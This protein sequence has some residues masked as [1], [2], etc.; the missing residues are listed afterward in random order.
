MFHSPT[1]HIQNRASERRRGRRRDHHPPPRAES[2]SPSADDRRGP[3]GCESV[4]MLLCIANLAVATRDRGRI[5]EGVGRAA[6]RGASNI[7]APLHFAWR[8]ALAPSRRR[9]VAP[10]RVLAFRARDGEGG[11]RSVVCLGARRSTSSRRPASHAHTHGKRKFVRGSHVAYRKLDLTFSA[12]QAHR[13][14]THE[15]PRAPARS[16]EEMM[17]DTSWQRASGRRSVSNLIANRDLTSFL[18]SSS[19][20]HSL[21]SLAFRTFF[22]PSRPLAPLLIRK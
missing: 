4:L 18:F 9:A 21:L 5:G 17:T 20:T 22:C 2:P 19:P 1:C 16:L 13:G 12:R 7:C 15:P 8:R 11:L 6:P 10:S 3:A 14:D